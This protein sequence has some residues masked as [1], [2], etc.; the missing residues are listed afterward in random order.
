ML[1][2]GRASAYT[3]F[4]D[5]DWDPPDTDLRDTVLVPILGTDL[6]AALRAKEITVVADTDPTEGACVRYYDNTMPLSPESVAALRDA[7]GGIAR[8]VARLNADPVELRRVLDAQ[9]YRLDH[10]ET[11]DRRLNYRRFFDVKTLVGLRQEDAPTY[12]QSHALILDLVKSEIVDGLRIDHID[13]LRDPG[14]YLRRL[15]EDAP[16][17]YV[18]VEKI[19]EP[20]EELRDEWPVEGTTG[21]DFLNLVGGLFVDPSGEKPLDT[22]YER[23]TGKTAG[24]AA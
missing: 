9:H 16:G 15:R 22:V 24:L 1:K 19:L 2:H 6:D 10:W 21:Y 5:V 12:E 18:V 23:I 17:A 14:A 8:G 3:R 13:G 20:G 7:S 11:G 4:F